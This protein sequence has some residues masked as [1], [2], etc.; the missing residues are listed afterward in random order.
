MKE[1]FYL[2]LSV[3]LLLSGAFYQCSEPVDQQGAEGDKVVNAKAKGRIVSE[4]T[5]AMSS[6]LA[7]VK[8]LD[9]EK[10]TTH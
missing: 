9:A 5:A 7:A 2:L 6:Y 8:S 10:V 4:V 3:A 1:R